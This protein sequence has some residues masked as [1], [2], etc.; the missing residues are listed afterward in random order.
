MP[1]RGRQS[2]R[3][4]QHVAARAQWRRC[5][6]NGPGSLSFP[7]PLGSVLRNPLFQRDT[8]T[9]VSPPFSHLWEATKLRRSCWQEAW[10]EVEHSLGRKTAVGGGGGGPRGGAPSSPVGWWLAPGL[11]LCHRGW[12]S[13][14][15]L[16]TLHHTHCPPLSLPPQAARRL[17]T[18][19]GKA[20]LL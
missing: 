5:Y 6:G 14:S 4:R 18:R 16:I 7:A 13:P 20:G 9:A 1:S 19:P 10:G 11:Q 3:A 15:E 17:G 2:A 12:R 8:C